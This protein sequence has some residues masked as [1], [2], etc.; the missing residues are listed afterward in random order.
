MIGY[1]IDS[2]IHQVILIERSIQ[3]SI[4]EK[5]IYKKYLLS[6]IYMCYEYQCLY[7]FTIKSSHTNSV[8]CCQIYFS[9]LYIQLTFYFPFRHVF[10]VILNGTQLLHY[11]H[12]HLF[13]LIRR[14]WISALSSFQD[15]SISLTA[16]VRSG[17]HPTQLSRSSSLGNLIGGTTVVRYAVDPIRSFP[18]SPHALST[19]DFTSVGH[20]NFS[21]SVKA[22][23]AIS[24]YCCS[25]SFLI[26]QTSVI[27]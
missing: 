14:C 20:L 2:A 10:P 23:S 8:I 11:T 6:D 26:I 7:Q 13:H 4:I 15:S 16:S 9:I 17:F 22:V 27:S 3:L 5:H 25:L 1:F 18:C 24:R 21:N 19:A 12:Q